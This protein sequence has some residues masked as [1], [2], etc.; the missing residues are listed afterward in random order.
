VGACD[1]WSRSGVMNIRRII[2]SAAAST[3][4]KKKKIVERVLLVL[5]YLG[6]YRDTNSSIVEKEDVVCDHNSPFT[7]TSD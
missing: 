1:I 2:F 4:K 5:S 6:Y 3:S 7:I